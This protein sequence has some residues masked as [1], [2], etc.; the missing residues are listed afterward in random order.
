MD[1]VVNGNRV[2]LISDQ[3]STHL[4]DHWW[5]RIVEHTITAHALIQ[6]ICIPLPTK[7]IQSYSS[8]PNEVNTAQCHGWYGRRQPAM[9]IHPQTTLCCDILVRIVLPIDLFFYCGI[10]LGQHDVSWFCLLLR[11]NSSYL[12]VGLRFSPQERRLVAS[13]QRQVEHVGS[14]R[15]VEGNAALKGFPESLGGFL[16]R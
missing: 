11:F 13:L 7:M 3:I 8:N 1:F 9:E 10:H 5:S 12:L 14:P 4:V 6:E 15:M 2:G 16:F